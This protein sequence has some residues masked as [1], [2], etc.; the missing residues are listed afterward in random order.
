MITQSEIAV[1]QKYLKTF[2]V[3]DTVNFFFTTNRPNAFTLEA[4]DRRYFVAEVKRGPLNTD[5]YMDYDFWLKYEG[6]A[7]NIFYY[8]LNYDV[9][10]FNPNGA[11][12]MNQAK[13]DM[14][15][16]CKSGLA[17]WVTMLAEQP[18]NIL[19]FGK[20]KI[21]RDIFTGRELLYIYDPDGKN[22]TTLGMFGNQ[23]YYS[24]IKKVNNGAKI[25]MSG[26][27][28]EYYYAVRNNN[29]WMKATTQE[30]KDHIRGNKFLNL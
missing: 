19:I 8:L 29:K 6:G 16:S 9:S 14:I 17:E 12:R 18:D 10:D 15:N 30:L 20:A 23:L 11:A 5:F 22:N 3:T 25:Q 2:K 1:N 21:D 26:N 7:A 4:E 24:G 27:R 28:D 13:I